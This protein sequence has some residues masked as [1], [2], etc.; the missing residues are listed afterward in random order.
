M[1]QCLCQ[2]SVKTKG[3]IR[4]QISELFWIYMDPDLQHVFIMFSMSCFLSSLALL[5]ECKAYEY[6]TLLFILCARTVTNAKI[7]CL[8]FSLQKVKMKM[9][10]Q[11]LVSDVDQ[12]DKMR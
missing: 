5:Q 7:A 1:Q 4:I 2:F 3:R 12:L 6:N 8:D 10:V 11:L 9:G